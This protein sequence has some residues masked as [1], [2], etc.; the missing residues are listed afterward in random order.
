MWEEGRDWFN[1]ILLMCVHTLIWCFHIHK[2][3]RLILLHPFGHKKKSTCLKQKG[4]SVDA[5]LGGRLASVLNTRCKCVGFVFFF[6][7]KIFEFPCSLREIPEMNTKWAA[8]TPVAAW[9]CPSHEPLA[10]PIS[11]RYK[12]KG[13]NQEINT[14]QCSLQ[15][16]HCLCD[17]HLK[18]LLL[19]IQG[20]FHLQEKMM[21]KKSY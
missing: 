15:W 1:S 16:Q 2:S 21:N 18:T 7:I 8:V 20:M 5:M 19:I 9:D 11:P 13:I 4:I 3:S 10:I 17:A 12:G 6:S 14:S